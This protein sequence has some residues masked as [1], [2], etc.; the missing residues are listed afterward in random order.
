MLPATAAQNTEADLANSKLLQTLQTHGLPDA[1]PGV[2]Y[3]RTPHSVNL[4]YHSGMVAEFL[5]PGGGL[6]AYQHNLALVFQLEKMLRKMRLEHRVA[7]YRFFT[8]A[9]PGFHPYML[10]VSFY[11]K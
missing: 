10:R 3:F 1:P 6:I 11:K 2:W 5:P 9:E 4:C 7:G 8:S